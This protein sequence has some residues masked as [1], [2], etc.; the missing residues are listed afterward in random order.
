MGSYLHNGLAARMISG[1]LNLDDLYE[2]TRKRA[3]GAHVRTVRSDQVRV[4]ADR[5]DT[6][7]LRLI[8]PGRD[9]EIVPTRR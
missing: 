4:E 3:E 2:A 7:T 9:A 6:E 5:D 8:L 1:F